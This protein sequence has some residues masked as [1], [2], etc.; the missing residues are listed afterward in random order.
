MP[1]L[2][3]PS[4]CSTSVWCL[5][6]SSSVLPQTNLAAKSHSSLLVSFRWVARTYLQVTKTIPQCFCKQG[7]FCIPLSE[8][9]EQTWILSLLFQSILGVATAF[10]PN[11]YVFTILRFFVGALEQ[12]CKKQV[13]FWRT[14]FHDDYWWFLG[15]LRMKTKMLLCSRV[16]T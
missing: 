11:F 14:G 9:N 2:K 5:V 13:F 12:V 4:W 15:A 8:P 16:S 1:C 10:S 3:H 7:R 6:G